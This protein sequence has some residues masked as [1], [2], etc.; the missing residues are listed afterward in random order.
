[1][2]PKMALQMAGITKSFLGVP[3]LHGVDLD[4]RAGEVHALVGENGAGKSTLLKV[5]SGVHPPDAGTVAIDGEPRV[6]ANPRQAQDAGV[7]IIHQEFA[8]LPER[9][10][11]QNVFLGREPVRRGLVDTSAMER[12][13]AALLAEIGETGFGPTEVVRRLSVAQQQVVEIVKALAVD[14]RIVAM[15]E[16]TAALAD[17]EVALLTDLIR[18]L[19][20][21]G[22]AVLY[23][24]HRLPEIFALADRITVLKD[25]ARVTT[26]PVAELDPSALVRLM[27]GRP[28]DAYYPPRATEVGE[29]RLEVRG[30]TAPAIR[31]VDLE[32]RAGEV[33]GL[34]GL[35]GAGRTELLRAIFGADPLTS[36]E[37][38]LDGVPVRLGS[39]RRAIAA[40]VAF[41]TED[42]K[43]EGLALSRSVRENAL[44]VLRAVFR[45]RARAGEV[46]TRDLL[47]S[48]G[49]RS[50]GE[51]QEVRFLS[52]GN[53]QKV[54]LAKWLAADPRVLLLD[55]PTRGIDVGAKAAVHELVRAQAAAGMA[56][57]LVCSELPELIGMSDRIVVLHEGEV[58]GELPAGAAEED[59]MALAT[60]G[61]RAPQGDDRAPG[62]RAPEDR[63]E[64]PR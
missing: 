28:L 39:P 59:V 45:R 58:A 17:H 38:R 37:V 4:V 20:R 44:L 2:T 40:G 23:V 10:V 62:D 6:F 63:T 35:Q 57:L 49:L 15:D 43:A 52:G 47:A 1:M 50:A 33:V 32:V 14:A 54:V 29:V 64:V 27:V 51:D 55:E 16:P 53:Q 7:A 12:D 60:G 9:T 19:T 22:I 36:G 25:G 31:G 8:L 3:V 24:S 18:R 48:V 30:G 11:A 56:V 42:R 21:R 41:V 13:T 61:H 34:A 5:L 26:R 46:R